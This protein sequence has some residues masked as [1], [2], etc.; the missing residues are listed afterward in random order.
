[1]KN[2][3][4]NYKEIIVL[5]AYAMIIAG[6]FSFVIK[7]LFADIEEKRNHKE[8]QL[9]DH[10]IK[11]KKVGELPEYKNKIELINQ[12]KGDLGVFIDSKYALPLIELLEKIAEQTGNKIQIDVAE[13][14]K[15]EYNKNNNKEKEEDNIK[16][17]VPSDNYL[18]MNIVL[19]GEFNSIMFFLK[20]LESMQY[21]SDVIS[22]KIENAEE[23]FI[24]SNKSDNL[25][26]V[27]AQSGGE[28]IAVSD[29]NLVLPLKASLEVIFYK[30]K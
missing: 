26:S 21:F 15:L 1:M 29:G 5:L 6:L 7:P 24:G 13:E 14:D 12:N 2:I 19:N 8:E 16:D 23:E 17:F 27:S 20:K 11:Q 3:W 9:V 4:N 22:I 30:E 28:N 25:L 10:K 18:T